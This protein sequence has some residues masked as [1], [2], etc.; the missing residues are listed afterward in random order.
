M[1]QSTA[2]KGGERGACC[3]LSS[4]DVSS[5]DGGA[6]PFDAGA[7]FAPLAAAGG[8][9]EVT[10][11][12]G[13]SAAAAFPKGVIAFGGG[14]AAGLPTALACGEASLGILFEDFGT[15]AALSFGPADE[16]SW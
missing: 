4:A 5:A 10:A 13:G 16:D 2:C 15:G 1:L 7:D 8:G 12:G 14:L 11:A 6:F 3:S 9:L